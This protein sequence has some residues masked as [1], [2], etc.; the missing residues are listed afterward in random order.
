M[1]TTRSRQVIVAGAGIAGLTAALAF[2]SRGFSVHVFERRD[3]PAEAGAGLQL[4]P[5]AT[6]I[7]ERLGVLRHLRGVAVQPEAV[8]LRD[9]ATLAELARVP[10]GASAEARWRAPYLVAHRADLLR[11]L[12]ATVEEEAEIRLTTAATVRDVAMHHQGVTASIDVG[13]TIRDVRGL[14]VVGADG[15]WSNL[16]SL[17]KGR[18]SQFS[19]QIAWRRTLSADDH[20]VKALGTARRVSAFLHP[21]CHLIAYPIRSGS[22]VNLVAFT[23]GAGLATEWST[24]ID[25]SPLAWAMQG[26]APALMEIVTDGGTWTAWPIHTVDCRLP[27]TFGS[28]LA[29]IGDAAHAMTPFA[30]QGA[31]MAIEDAETLAA[32]VASAPDELGPALAAW[33]TARRQ[34]V[35]RVARR[36]AFNKLAWQASGPVARIR[37][38]I[39][40]H[41]SPTRLAADMDW[42]YGWEATSPRRSETAGAD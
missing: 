29:L 28:G 38:A 1:E 5:N 12:L 23:S 2:A 31:A 37:D 24:P 4:S 6:R 42:L 20:G 33:E 9:M 25:P 41:R 19:G 13:Q 3:E 7:L 30:A 40:R 14:L 21:G 16:R 27:W 32:H 10:L 39:L 18:A 35:L 34:R 8:V 22:A 26:A 36:G 15:V 17:A 11:A